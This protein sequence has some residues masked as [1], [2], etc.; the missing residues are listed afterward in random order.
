MDQSH[1][2]LGDQAQEG[3]FLW[4][5]ITRDQFLVEPREGIAGDRSA[6]EER[7][8][9]EGYGCIEECKTEVPCHC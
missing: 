9:G 1:Q 7:G 3:R 4:H 8:T 5:G 2:S 6:V